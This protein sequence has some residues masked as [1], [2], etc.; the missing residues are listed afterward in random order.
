MPSPIIPIYVF[1][2]P[3]IIVQLLEVADTLGEILLYV[4]F[5]VPVALIV[6]LIEYHVFFV[7][8]GPLQDHSH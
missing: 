4:Y 6:I 1:N 8:V 3:L 7:R 5:A 2:V